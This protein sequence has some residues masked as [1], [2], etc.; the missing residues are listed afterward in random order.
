MLKPIYQVSCAPALRAC[1]RLQTQLLD[2]LCDPAT[3]DVTQINLV[4]PHIPTQIEADWLWGFLQRKLAGKPLLERA[5]V[6]AGMTQAEKSALSLWA[7][8]V[9]AIASQF[10]PQPPTWPENKAAIPD[11]AWIAFKE[12]MEAFY[13]KGLNSTDGIPYLADGTPTAGSGVNYVHFVQEFLNKHRLAARDICVLCGGHLGQTPQVD[14][15]IAKSAYP[16]LSVC[17]DNLLPI[18]SVCNSTTNKGEK[19]VHTHSQFDDWFHPYLRHANDTI[20]LEYNIQ[21]LSLAVAATSPAHELKVA[22][23]NRLLNL[24]ARWTREFKAEYAKQQ[25]ILVNREKRRIVRQEARHTQSE[26]QSH[27]QTVHDDLL[28]SEPHHEVHRI[29]CKAML[30]KARLASWQQELELL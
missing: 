14:H 3:A 25:S 27:L 1:R 29:L 5:Q 21:T 8:T 9:S 16:L 19:P 20:R 28:P 4:P 26:V 15:W 6:L 22:N 30:D 7:Q 18:C 10:Q 12:L 17:A 24:S 2:W 13:D 11:S 23:L